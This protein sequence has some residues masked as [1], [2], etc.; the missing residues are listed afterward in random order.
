MPTSFTTDRSALVDRDIKDDLVNMLPYGPGFRFVDRIIK[1]DNEGIEGE[2]T[3][4][5]DEYFYPYHF[6]DEP[7]TPGVI[8]TE[9]MAQIGLVSLGLY[10]N[11]NNDPTHIR[12][13]FASSQVNYYMVVLPGE[14]VTVLATKK[15]YRMGTLKCSIE[16]LNGAGHKVC[17]G[18]LT[19]MHM[20]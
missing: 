18:V 8:L 20:R 14:T 13:A 5:L 19:G 6:R 15:Y 10:L 3:F 1:V 11:R 9:C 7:I 17:E 16:M 12:F 2:Y 4:R